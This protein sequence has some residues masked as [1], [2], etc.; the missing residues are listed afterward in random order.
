VFEVRRISLIHAVAVFAMLLVGS[1]VTRTLHVMTAHSA[2]SSSASC[3]PTVPV[4]VSPC[5]SHAGH[6]HDAHDHGSAPT[7]CEDSGEDSHDHD[8]CPTCLT[9]AAL[10]SPL[11][12]I[13]P[14]LPPVFDIVDIAP[15]GRTVVSRRPFGVVALRGPPSIV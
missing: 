13:T 3:C 11:L 12:T 1:G 8:R 6:A 5:G 4:K 9:L 7:P 2:S 15:T 10:A 14:Q